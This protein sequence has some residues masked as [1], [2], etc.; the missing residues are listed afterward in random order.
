VQFA[1]R[2]TSAAPRGIAEDDYVAVECRGRVKIDQENRIIT[3]IATFAAS[4][5]AGWPS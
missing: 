3:P 2:Y 1:E 5:T 4:P